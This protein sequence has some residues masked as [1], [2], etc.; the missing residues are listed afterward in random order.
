VLTSLK[1]VVVAVTITAVLACGTVLAANAADTT[2]SPLAPSPS[3]APPPTPAA[4]APSVRGSWVITP[5]VPGPLFQ[6]LAAF[7]AG[8][9]FVTTGSDQAGTGIG[10]WA[11]DGDTGFVFGYRNFHF[12][13]DGKLATI[14]TVTATGTFGGDT[15]TGTAT[16]SVAD[17]SGASMGPA[18]TM[19]FTGERMQATAP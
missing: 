4:N 5:Q 14:T 19:S 10:E 6:A 18:Q 1:G 3:V 8:G 13:P 15:M 17:A 2:T 16:E 9:S 11:A 12:G 7:D